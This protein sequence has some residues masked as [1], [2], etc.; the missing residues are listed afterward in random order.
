MN[1]KQAIE[2]LDALQHN[3]YSREQKIAW[4]DELD[5]EVKND[6][7]DTHEGEQQAFKGYDSITDELTELLIPAPYDKAY[8]FWLEAHVDYYNGE[9]DRYQNAQGMFNSTYS[10]FINHYNRT[11]MPKGKKFKF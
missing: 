3:T 1:I 11:H 4:L 8:L 10:Q 2:N 7:L 9:T 5:R 6:V